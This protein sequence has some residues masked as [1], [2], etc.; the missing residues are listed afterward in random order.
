MR[1]GSLLAIAVVAYCFYTAIPLGMG[2]QADAVKVW[3]GMAFIAAALGIAL[4]LAMYYF[5]AKSIEASPGQ[6][7]AV[8]LGV[9]DSK[10]SQRHAATAGKGRRKGV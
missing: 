8:T 4:A 3:I 1:I 6:P 5:H 7:T 10:Q 9:A 2:G